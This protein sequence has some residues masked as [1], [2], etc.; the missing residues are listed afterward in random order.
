MPDGVFPNN[1]ISTENDGTITIY[2]MAA[3]SRNKE[4]HAFRYVCE[5]LMD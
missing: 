1:W 5:L 4:K 3:E 2:P